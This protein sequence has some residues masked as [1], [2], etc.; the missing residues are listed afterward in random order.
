MAGVDVEVLVVPDCPHRAAA[1]GL[2]RELLAELRLPATPVRVGVID[3]QAEAR[4]RGFAG[5]PTILIDGVDPFAQPGQAA[6]LACRIYRGEAGA[7]PLPDKQALRRILRAAR[8]A[9]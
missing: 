7:G 4:R 6:A 2:V 9:D 3:S 1:V 5:S 8:T